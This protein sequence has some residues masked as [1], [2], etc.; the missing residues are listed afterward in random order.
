M[1]Q[2][3]NIENKRSSYTHQS[4]LELTSS[5]NVDSIGVIASSAVCRNP[6]KHRSEIVPT[7]THNKLISIK[8]QMLGYLQIDVNMLSESN[9][10][11]WTY[12]YR[13]IDYISI[14]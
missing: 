6:E 14:H 11:L 9:D 12:I 4:I 10:E 1:S 5:E 2:K 3:I 7:K 8:L 13:V